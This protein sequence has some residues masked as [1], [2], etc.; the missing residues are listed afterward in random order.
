M[1]LHIK[2]MIFQD[3]RTDIDGWAGLMHV[4]MC[5]VHNN[6]RIREKRKTVEDKNC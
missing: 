4:S 1:F 3:M 2:M 6:N 5:L